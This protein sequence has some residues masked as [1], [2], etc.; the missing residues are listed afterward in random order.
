MPALPDHCVYHLYFT[1]ALADEAMAI[2]TW[3]LLTAAASMTPS[4]SLT[5]R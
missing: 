3:L 4:S 1:V 2:C 5:L